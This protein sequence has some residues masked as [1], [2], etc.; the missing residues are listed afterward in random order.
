VK[1]KPQYHR[2]MK[3]DYRV[4]CPTEVRQRDSDDIYGEGSVVF[5]GSEDDRLVVE[6]VTDMGGGRWESPDD[7]EDA[8]RKTVL[9]YCS[10]ASAE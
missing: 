3:Y 2:G 9:L 6:R 1:A 10:P 7:S 4:M 5:G 8:S